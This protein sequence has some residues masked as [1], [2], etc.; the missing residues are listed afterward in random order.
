MVVADVVHA[1]K[2]PAL[3]QAGPE[4]LE[5]LLVQRLHTRAIV[6]C[7]GATPRGLAVRRRVGEEQREIEHLRPWYLWAVHPLEQLRPPDD[8]VERAIAQL[9]ENAA[10]VLGDPGE[11]GHDLLR[12][13]C[14]LF[15]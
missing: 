13:A 15:P 9:G 12:R 11:I 8:V 10:H 5:D 6:A 3:V 4:R 2:R 14:E 7:H 1:R